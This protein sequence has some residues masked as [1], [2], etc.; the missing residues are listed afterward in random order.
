VW[1]KRLLQSPRVKLHT[2]LKP[3]FATGVCNVAIE[4]IDPVKLQEH[5][6]AKHRIFT[7]A[8]VH[9]EFRGVRISP[10]VY[11][12]MEELDRFCAAMEAV[13]ENGLPG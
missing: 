6:W 13:I 8:I 5:L 9:D 4:G 3:G 1:A 10:A 7:V 12:T 2:S 11:T